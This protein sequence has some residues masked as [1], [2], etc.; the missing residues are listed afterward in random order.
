[1]ESSLTALRAH[2]Q[3]H[4]K[5]GWLTCGYRD[6][7][8]DVLPGRVVFPVATCVYSAVTLGK[9]HRP[10]RDMGFTEGVKV[11]LSS[12]TNTLSPSFPFGN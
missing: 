10:Q 1:M 2:S 12:W 7:R 5:G 4:E 11:V 8:D 9:R 6:T 3:S